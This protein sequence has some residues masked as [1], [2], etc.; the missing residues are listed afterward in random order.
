[1]YNS[2]TLAEVAQDM[3][4]LVYDPAESS[5]RSRLM[6]LPSELLTDVLEC[7]ANVDSKITNLTLVHRRFT[8]I[9]R[10]ILYKV[11]GEC[12]L[13]HVAINWD[14]I[15]GKELMDLIMKGIDP[16]TEDKIT[17]GRLQVALFLAAKMGNKTLVEILLTTYNFVDPYE[18]CTHYFAG[19]YLV[20]MGDEQ[21]ASIEFSDR[22]YPIKMGT[23]NSPHE[24]AVEGNH[25]EIVELMER[26]RKS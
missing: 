19:R 11:H 26:K 16:E 9:V 17:R 13:E 24:L 10:P 12:S 22:I 25:E 18:R 4:N 14:R 23:H 5:G 6:N 20:W 8:A 1:M 15:Q 3:P 2:A 21:V 7:V